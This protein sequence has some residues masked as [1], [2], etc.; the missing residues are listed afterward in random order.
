MGV[1]ALK[2]IIMREASRVGVEDEVDE[3]RPG[4]SI[5]RT[6]HPGPCVWSH[7]FG[8]ARGRLWRTSGDQSWSEGC[9]R[10]EPY[11]RRGGGVGDLE[12]CSGLD[13]QG[14]GG[15]EGA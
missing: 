5:A 9:G 3:I 6:V 1:A 12:A 2:T 7:P 10:I 4:M 15:V 8:R 11:G 13:E 14:G